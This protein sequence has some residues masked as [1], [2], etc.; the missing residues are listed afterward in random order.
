M[1]S[2]IFAKSKMRGKLT[3]RPCP[4]CDDLRNTKQIY[5]N[6]KQGKIDAINE[7][8]NDSDII[9]NI[10]ENCEYLYKEVFPTDEIKVHF[11]YIFGEYFVYLN[12]YTKRYRL[13]DID[14]ALAFAYREGIHS[15]KNIDELISLYHDYMGRDYD[16]MVSIIGTEYEEYVTL[17]KYSIHQ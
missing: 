17:G 5:I 14:D 4:C 10:A 16:N 9:N 3:S 15:Y 13:D 11:N 2:H 6:S 8:I 1:P 7:E 12:N